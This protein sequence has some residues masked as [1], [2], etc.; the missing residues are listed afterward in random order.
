MGTNLN[1]A[2]R[3]PRDNGHQRK[4][5]FPSISSNNGCNHWAQQRFQYQFKQLFQHQFAHICIRQHT[6]G[7]QTYL[8]VHRACLIQQ[9]FFITPGLTYSLHQQQWLV[10]RKTTH[11]V[12]DTGN[13]TERRLTPLGAVV[14]RRPV[15]GTRETRSI[16]LTQYKKQG[17]RLKSRY[18]SEAPTACII[19][20]CL[21]V[22]LYFCLFNAAG[23]VTGSCGRGLI[24]YISSTCNE[25]R[26]DYS[27]SE[28]SFAPNTARVWG[29]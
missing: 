18:V 3:V 6:R 22:C 28:T 14:C 11:C 21:F 5:R 12:A 19:P 9:I 25:V 1:S 13:T 7:K 10:C 27:G 24:A 29:P 15:K 16:Y 23:S 2:C 17:A 4:Q 8:A 20:A 26:L